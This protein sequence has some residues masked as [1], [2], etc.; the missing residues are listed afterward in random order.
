MASHGDWLLGYIERFQVKKFLTPQ[1][2]PI[3]KE[4]RG[5]FYTILLKDITHVDK[6]R[7]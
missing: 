3:P 6:S 2:N 4:V 5:D 7:V 1:P